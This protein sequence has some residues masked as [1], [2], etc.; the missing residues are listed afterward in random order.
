MEICASQST[1]SACKVVAD[2][3]NTRNPQRHTANSTGNYSIYQLLS[4][5]HLAVTSCPGQ[6][7]LQSQSSSIYSAQRAVRPRQTNQNKKAEINWDKYT[8][9][10]TL[11]VHKGHSHPPMP[12]KPEEWC[13][14][15]AQQH[16]SENEIILFLYQSN[17]KQNCCCAK[18]SL[19]SIHFTLKQPDLLVIFLSE[20]KQW[21]SK[22]SKGLFKGLFKFSLDIGCF[23]TR[24]LFSPWIFDH[25]L[26][27]WLFLVFV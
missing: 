15:G 8:W 7:A 23:C 14:T 17:L 9:I 26:R 1:P 10:I 16:F 21:F 11:S 6:I 20:F 3:L 5:A 25:F 27:N 13:K 2:A 22:L 12:I 18:T 4:T 19:I 24:F